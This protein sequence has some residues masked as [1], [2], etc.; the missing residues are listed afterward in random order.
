LV[1]GD[2]FKTLQND[3]NAREALQF[4]LAQNYLDMG[5]KIGSSDSSK[6]MFMDPRSI[7]ATLEGMRSIVGE[8]SSNE[9]KK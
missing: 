8:G 2:C 9:V 6:V 4:L 5:L 7:P 1:L 3:P